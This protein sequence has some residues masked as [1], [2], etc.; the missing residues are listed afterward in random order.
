MPDSII[1]HLREENARLKKILL[2]F[3]KHTHEKVSA[4][5]NQTSHRRYRRGYDMNC[6]KCK[7][8]MRISVHPG[9]DGTVYHYYCQNCGH[10]HD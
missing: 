1:D 4:R 8:P 7:K 5:D 6:E 2:E 10:S 3:K 9:T